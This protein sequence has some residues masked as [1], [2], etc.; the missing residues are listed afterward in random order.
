MII[1]A[2]YVKK[3]NVNGTNP[4][5]VAPSRIDFI[6]YHPLIAPLSLGRNQ[7]RMQHFSREIGYIDIQESIIGE[8]MFRYDDSQFGGKGSCRFEICTDSIY[9]KRDRKSR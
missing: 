3:V 2:L 5:I 7:W 6:N 8:A 1:G 4:I 9:D